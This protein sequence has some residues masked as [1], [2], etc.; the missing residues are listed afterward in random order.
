MASHNRRDKISVSCLNCGEKET[1]QM[2]QRSVKE[3]RL[4]KKMKEDFTRSGIHKF[5]AQQTL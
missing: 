5:E 2:N 1:M 4:R 3:S